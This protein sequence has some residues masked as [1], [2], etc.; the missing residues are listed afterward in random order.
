MFKVPTLL[1]SQETMRVSGKVVDNTTDEELIGVSVVEKGTLRGAVTDIDGNFAF[2]ATVGS[3][4]SVSFIG[5]KTLEIEASQNLTIR[6]DISDQQLDEVVVMGYTVQKK[7]DVF[8]S[9]SKLENTVLTKTPSPNT[10][11]AMQGRVAGVQVSTQSGAPGSNVS[12]RVHGVGSITSSNEP[13]YIIDGIPVERGLENISQNDIDNITILKDAASA[14]IYGSRATNGVV[15]I[16]TKSGKAGESKITYNG[17]F[18][19]QTHPRLTK[20]A[21]TAQYI[22]MYNEA[23]RNDNQTSVIQRALIQ[24]D[25]LKNFADVNYIEEIFRIAPIQTHELSFSG[26]NEKSQ[27]LVSLSYFD[28]EGIIKT[29]T[30]DRF[31]IRSNVNSKVKNWLQVGLN[32]NVSN[33][34]TRKVSSSG[35]GYAGEGGSVVRYAFFRNPAIPIYNDNNEFIDL[36]SSYFDSPL[37]NSFFGDGYN[38]IG[39]IEN[40]DMTEKVKALLISGNMLI[41]LPANFFIKTNIGADYNSKYARN[42]YPTWGYN[43]EIYRINA[44]NSLSVSDEKFMTVTAYSTINHSFDITENHNFNWFLGVEAISENGEVIGGSESVLPELVY[45]GKGDANKVLYQGE[46]GANL[47]SFIGTINYNFQQK[48]YLTLILRED[49]SSRFTEGNRWGTFYS[50]SGGWNVESEEFMAAYPNIS[51]LKISAGF[52]AIGNQKIGYYANLDRI[53]ELHY[54]A[55]G[56]K[57]HNGAI[58]TALGNSDLKW[59]T[60]NQLSAGIDL[61]LWKNSVGISVDYFYKVT[62]GM[63]IIAS[64]PPSTGKASPPT[65][66]FGS[67]L[68]TGIDIELFYRKRLKNGGYEIKLNGGFLHNEVLSMDAPVEAGRIDS[69]VNATRTETGHPIGSFFLYEMDGIFQNE[70]EV[71]L[72]AYQGRNIQPG[73]VRYKDNNNDG[74][75]TAADRA[76]VGSAIPK[77]TTGLTF[78]GNYKQWD[79]NIFF[80]GAFGQKIYSQVNHDIEGFYRGFNVTKRYYDERWTG[81]GTS[82]T[83]PRASWSAKQNNARTGTTRFLEDGSY[84]RLKNIQLGYSIPNSGKFKV[85]SFRLYVAATNIFT[86]TKYSGLDPEMTIST[87]AA[88]QGDI[89]NGIDW[90]TYPVPRCYTFGLNIIF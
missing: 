44:Q 11:M 56:D 47:L 41:T 39:L 28:Q 73:D 7:R 87:N 16:T 19:I 64:Y 6:L 85:D 75:I 26:G 1:Y 45:L 80:Q 31:N 9:V 21:N 86:F 36:P 4:L 49:G 51:K 27:Y 5:Y 72:S 50:V 34:S 84:L 30:Y 25:Y 82:N 8:G 37:Y 12:V 38:P 46:W 77:F 43:N 3:T 71:M 48:Y 32:I 52:G 54:Y 29:T 2:N 62:D 10:Q 67:V 42:F 89:A 90:G 13:L 61:E 23:A 57:S 17:Q 59:E 60:S 58:I 65:I 74:F 70:M 79:V 20:M 63:L 15:L 55:F 76:H 22:E 53:G 78:E 69:G 81:E 66:N 40:T 14:A 68:N 35:D 83:Q 33:A 88:G 18:G 24:G